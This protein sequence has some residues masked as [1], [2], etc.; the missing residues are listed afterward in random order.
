MER[1]EKLYTGKRNTHKDFYFNGKRVH[2]QDLTFENL[3]DIKHISV[4]F[5][6]TD[7]ININLKMLCDTTFKAMFTDFFC[8]LLP[9]WADFEDFF[10][11]LFTHEI[12]HEYIH[13]ILVKLGCD[14]GAWDNL[15]LKL[16]L[17][18]CLNV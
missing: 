3:K 9:P 11:K 15:P 4:Y 2:T 1:Y 10:I 13:R 16:Q 14:S 8:N 6:D 5:P 18:V 7:T 17:E 12:T